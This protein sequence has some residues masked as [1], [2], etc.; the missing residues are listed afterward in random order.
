M[1][2][3]LGLKHE[4]ER[5]TGVD[6]RRIFGNEKNRLYGLALL[7]T[8]NHGIAERCVSA[9][10]ADCVDTSSVFR[11]W[12]FSW[13]KRAVIKNAIRLVAPNPKGDRDATPRSEG[14]RPAKKSMLGQAVIELTQFRRFAVVMSVLE[15]YRDKDCGILLNC[16][17]EEVAKARNEALR[18]LASKL[19]SRSAAAL[20]TNASD[21]VWPQLLRFSSEND[22]THGWE[23][24]GAAGKEF[25]AAAAAP[26]P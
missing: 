8:A 4:C 16:A 12:S 3:S 9:A 6:F 24:G 26:I 7:L 20:F 21:T 18:Q 13:S 19:G 15:G 5:A 22:E 14:A 2:N 23:N 10:F 1:A 25:P 17:A 11:E